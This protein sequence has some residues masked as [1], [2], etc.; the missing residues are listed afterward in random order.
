MRDV[1]LRH[2]N[3][4]FKP[5][6]WGLFGLVALVLAVFSVAYCGEGGDSQSGTSSSLRGMIEIDGSST[7]FPLTEAVAEEF[8]KVHPRVQVN[9]GA[10][11]TGGGFKRFLDGE[12][13]IS[14]ASRPISPEEAEQANANGIEF[15][16][17]RVGIDGLSIVVNPR[18]DFVECLTLAEL[19]R[20]WEP[21]SRINNW[22]Q[23][24]PEFPDRRLRL[25]G[26]DTDSGTFDYFTEQINGRARASRPDYT[27]SA[28]DFFL[29]RG[30]AG[31][32]SALGYFGYAYYV[33]NPDKLKLVAVEA[34]DGC[35]KPTPQT[36][37]SGEYSPLS[38]PLFIYVSNMSLERQEVKTFVEFYIENAAQLIPRIGYVALQDFV[39]AEN[40]AR[41]K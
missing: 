7:V 9:I 10:S 18:N 21:G 6:L 30:I 22:N 33:E 1:T 16:E 28:S 23:V 36:V 3:W 26:P 24:R 19:K 31:D 32:R 5:S 2:V 17:L 41:V 38:R 14:D 35:V 34:R 37:R 39:Y 20:I 13:D 15:V 29:V 11:G 12:T 8:R 27:A 25:Y 40:L 4:M